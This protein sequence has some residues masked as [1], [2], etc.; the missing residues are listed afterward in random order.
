MARD[1]SG[2]GYV[3]PA[4]ELAYDTHPHS[5]SHSYF[6]MAFLFELSPLIA[7]FVAYRL[8]GIYVAT[9]VIIGA[10]ALQVGYRVIR[11][12]KLTTLQK[13]SAAA[14]LAL[15][16]LTL[17]LHDDRFILWKPTIFYWGVS[18]GLMLGHFVTGK[19]VVEKLLGDNFK[20]SH[21]RW[22]LLSWIWVGVFALLG[23]LNLFIAFNF[24]R[25]TWVA[26]KFVL[27]A[28]FVVFMFVQVWWIVVRW[29]GIEEERLHSSGD[30]GS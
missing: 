6:Q 16:G 27:L 11:K 2:F 17:L 26:F 15:G 3:R 5:C 30:Q 20:L 1:R 8:W 14:L 12:E 7:F 4:R 28:I 13:G 23:V 10:V 22:V 24:S 9:G 29:N 21:D 19:P 18:I 25:D